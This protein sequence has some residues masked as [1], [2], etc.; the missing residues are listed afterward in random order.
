MKMKI[1]LIDRSFYPDLSSSREQPQTPIEWDRNCD[2]GKEIVIT[3][4]CYDFIRF[5]KKRPIKIAWIIEPEAIS[6]RVYEVA[7]KQKKDEFDFILT[8]HSKYCDNEKVLYYFFGGAWIKEDQRIIYNKTKGISATISNKNWTEGHN[9]RHRI[10]DKFSDTIDLYGTAYKFVPEKLDSLKDYRFSVIIENSKEEG[11]VTEKLIDCMLTG[12]VPIYWGSTFSHISS[13]FN[14]QGVIYC[15]SE[16]ELMDAIISIRKD[17]ERYYMNF[18]PYLQ[19]N[20]EKAK[21]FVSAEHWIF[22]NL[23]DRIFV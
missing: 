19:E 11:Y 20:L 15:E 23:S 7:L 16:T 3:D 9:L 13:N 21:Q 5:Y 22:N 6:P 4:L 2:Q 12:T 18:D 1:D 14:S 8:N 17:S 10:A